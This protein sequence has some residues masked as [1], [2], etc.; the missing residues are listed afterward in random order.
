MPDADGSPTGGRDDRAEQKESGAP[1]SDGTGGKQQVDPPEYRSFGD[2]K[3]TAD[4]RVAHCSWRGHHGRGRGQAFA[5]QG[6]ANVNVA[7]SRERGRKRS[8]DEGVVPRRSRSDP[9]DPA[10][11]AFDVR[12]L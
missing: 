6:D 2:F 7:R 8:A 9:E 4:G 11:L 12:P 1:V 3:M 5:D 10:L